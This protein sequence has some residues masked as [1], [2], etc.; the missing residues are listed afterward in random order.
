MISEKR[1]NK[2]MLITRKEDGAIMTMV[3][4][5]PVPILEYPHPGAT[6]MV[7]S[8]TY[9]KP[10]ICYADETQIPTDTP[11]HPIAP[12]RILLS[13]DLPGGY[14]P[15]T[16]PQWAII[17]KYKY[18][19]KRYALIW[20]AVIKCGDIQHAPDTE[21]NYF[22]DTIIRGK[23]YQRIRTQPDSLKRI[24]DNRGETD[25]Q[26]TLIY[27]DGTGMAL[28]WNCYMSN[29]IAYNIDKLPDPLPSTLGE[30]IVWLELP[31]RVREYVLRRGERL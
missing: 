3:D 29:G 20:D 21:W 8:P 2:I 12:R 22:I 19:G 14:D 10:L 18:K 13:Y 26:Y 5:K 31:R 17:K 4:N 11:I 25:D 16:I 28:S 15:S 30:E 1:R 23:E 9:D 6:H 27:K 7:L 24:F